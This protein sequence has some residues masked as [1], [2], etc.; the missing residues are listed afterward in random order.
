MSLDEKKPI[1]PEF[2]DSIK[3]IVDGKW[4]LEKSTTKLNLEIKHIKKVVDGKLFCIP[5]DTKVGSRE[6]F[7]LHHDPR[8]FKCEE[9]GAEKVGNRRMKDHKR[10]H[11]SA[12]CPKCNKTYGNK[13]SLWTHKQQCIYFETA[14]TYDCDQCSYKSF[15]NDALKSHKEVNHSNERLLKAMA[16]V[17]PIK[18]IKKEPKIPKTEAVED[19][20]SRI[21][22]KKCPYCPYASKISTNFKQHVL[23]SC[24]GLQDKEV[25][26]LFI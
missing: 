24:K 5:C 15:R 20:L 2:L 25:N 7:Q 1:K 18:I 6:H 13:S 12:T 16:Q 11:Q 14:R 8:I 22:E 3:K 10:K 9:C 21:P 19:R 17:G 26:V 23:E 4:T